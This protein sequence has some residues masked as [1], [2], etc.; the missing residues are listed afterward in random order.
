MSNSKP[1]L[2][3]VRNVFGLFSQ[4]VQLLKELASSRSSALIAEASRS[5]E[6]LSALEAEKATNAALK[7]TLVEKASES[8]NLAIQIVTLTEQC[9]ATEEARSYAISQVDALNAQLQEKKAELAS[10]EAAADE[11]AAAEVVEDTQQAEAEAALQTQISD[12]EVEITSLTSEI[13]E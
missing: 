1:N 13:A 10:A 7:A 3:S 8:L 4:K 5:A 9:G 2:Q 11:L 6:L 12:L